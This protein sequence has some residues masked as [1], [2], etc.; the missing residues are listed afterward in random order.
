[1]QYNCVQYF[2]GV[3]R[4]RN[5]CSKCSRTSADDHYQHTLKSRFISVSIFRWKS[6]GL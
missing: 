5:G 4:D 2:Q 1:M 6:C 3:L